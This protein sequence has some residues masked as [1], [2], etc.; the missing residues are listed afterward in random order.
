MNLWRIILAA[1]GA[2]VTYFIIGG[3]WASL[4]AFRHEFLRYPGVYRPMDSMKSVMPF[5]MLAMFLS[6]LA[7]TV[8]YAMLPAPASGLIQGARFGA[9]IGVF[10]AGAFVVHN[11]VNLQIGIRLTT[12]QAFVY[13]FQWTIIGMV[14]G[15]IYK[16]VAAH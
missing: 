5:G 10:T 12:E 4:P 16:P 3:L 15:V 13:L 9:L 2:F 11:Y 1:L 7:L 6:I 8:L 14:I